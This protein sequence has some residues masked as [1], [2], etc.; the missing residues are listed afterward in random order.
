MS[1]LNSAAIR[2]SAITLGLG[3][4]AIAYAAGALNVAAERT[5][6]QLTEQPSDA[7]QVLAVQQRLVAAKK[8]LNAPKTEEVVITG[9]LGGMPNVW[10]DTHPDFPWYK[11]QASFF[12]VDNK[13]ASQ[14]ESHRN[15]HGKWDGCAFCRNQAA[16]NAHAIAV[17]NLVNERGEIL[18]VDTRELLT[19]KETQTITVRGKAKLLG[20]AMLVIDAEGVYVGDHSATASTPQSRAT[21]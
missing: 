18:R 16:K 12:V 11:G 4:A 15:K 21:R 19:M 6:L 7:E 10:P 17:V 8:Q 3:L 20:G 2:L 13:V 14:F 5:R 1:L 9:K